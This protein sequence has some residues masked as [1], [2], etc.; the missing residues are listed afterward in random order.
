MPPVS[1]KTEPLQK[2][3]TS[4]SQPQ[5]HKKSSVVETAHSYKI[6]FLQDVNISL[7][8]L[9]SAGCYVRMDSILLLHVAQFLYIFFLRKDCHKNH[10]IY[11]PKGGLISLFILYQAV[12]E[13]LKN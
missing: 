2:K 6:K 1:F 13:S 3:V 5:L 11:C 4:L 10:I 12:S 7:R 8:L 9:Y